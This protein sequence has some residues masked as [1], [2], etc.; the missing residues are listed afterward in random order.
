MTIAMLKILLLSLP[1]FYSFHICRATKFLD[2]LRTIRKQGTIID[3]SLLT[4]PYYQYLD[5]ELWDSTEYKQIR[6]VPQRDQFVTE[7]IDVLR[8]K[9]NKDI[10]QKTLK[11]DENSSRG[12]RSGMFHREINLLQRLSMF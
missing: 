4:S 5:R 2:R 7:T 10:Y 8:F 12:K 6:Y 3:T 1:I 11:T 9:F